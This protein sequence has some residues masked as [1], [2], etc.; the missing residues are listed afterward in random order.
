MR[1]RHECFDEGLIGYV[2]CCLKDLEVVSIEGLDGGGEGSW[3]EVCQG[4][5]GT[6]CANEGLDCRC[7]DA[8]SWDV[9]NYR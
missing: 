5:A 7:A 8:C 4:E 6:A 9:V 1:A 2:A 3:V